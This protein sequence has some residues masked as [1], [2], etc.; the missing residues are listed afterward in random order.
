MHLSIIL[1]ASEYF[2]ETLV[3]GDSLVKEWLPQGPQAK[4]ENLHQHESQEPW[5]NYLLEGK[6]IYRNLNSEVFLV[7]QHLH[8]LDVSNLG[9]EPSA[10]I[11]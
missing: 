5:P 11:S 9:L 7:S 8:G 6:Y 1:N 10:D 3:D 4:C 2:I